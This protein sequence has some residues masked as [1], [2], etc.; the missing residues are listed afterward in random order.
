M[1]LTIAISLRSGVGAALRAILGI[2][3][4]SLTYLAVAM[5]GLLAVL[6][7]HRSVFHGLQIAGAGYLAY[8]GG[9]LGDRDSGPSGAVRRAIWMTALAR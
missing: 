1:P 8:L 6:F 5:A 4:G 2:C 3:T 9:P 7:A